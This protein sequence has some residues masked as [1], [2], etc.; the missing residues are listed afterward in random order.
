MID[1]SLAVASLN[2]SSFIYYTGWQ[3]P[4]T[5]RAS[6]FLIPNATVDAV[7]VLPIS[8]GMWTFALAAWNNA[9]F[10]DSVRVDSAPSPLVKT[11]TLRDE[12]GN[13]VVVVVH[14]GYN[15]T[16]AMGVSVSVTSD[17]PL[18]S[19][20]VVVRLEAASVREG[21]DIRLAGLTFR[22][23]TDGKTRAVDGKGPVV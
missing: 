7:T 11:W 10:I 3:E 12:D 15:E 4:P 14:K 22:D 18:T 5:F 17:Q 21:D 16:S 6:P 13:V 1:Y 20:A 9:R 23:T 19:P 8:Y 2:I